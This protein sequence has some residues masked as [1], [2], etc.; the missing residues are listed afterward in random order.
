M[1]KKQAYTEMGDAASA[2]EVEKEIQTEQE[3]KSYD[4]KLHNYQI[5][6]LQAQMDEQRALIQ[7]GTLTARHSGYVTYVMDISK[8]RTAASNQNVVVVSDEDDVYIE[9]TGITLKTYAYSDYPVKYAKIN[10]KDYDV[11]EYGYAT[12]EL[13]FAQTTGNFPYVRLKTKDTV[14][15]S[16]GDVVPVYYCKEDRRN[17]LV[18]GNDSLYNEGDESFVYVQ[19]EDEE[20]KRRDVELGA[21]DDNYTEVLGGV[22]E[23]EM[24]YYSSDSTVPAD[25]DEY[26]VT[27]AD[28]TTTQTTTSYQNADS[29]YIITFADCDAK[30]A[31][32]AVKEGESVK[33]GDLLCTLDTGGSVAALT[34]AGYAVKNEEESYQQSVKNYDASITDLNNQI[35]E[36]RNT[37]E[38][39]AT[40]TDAVQEYQ[41]NHLYKEEQLSLEIDIIAHQKEIARLQHE[42]DA[43]SLNATYASLSDGSNGVNIYAEADG[44]IADIKKNAGDAVS[45][46]DEILSTGYK[47]ND[48]LLVKM[49]RYRD[50]SNTELKSAKLGQTITFTGSDN[51][52]YTGSCTGTC[53]DDEKYYLSTIDGV[54]YETVSKAVSDSVVQFYADVDDESFY[55]DMPETT[56]SFSDISLSSVT[57][58]PKSMVYTEHDKAKNIDFNYVWKLENGQFIKQYVLNDSRFSSDE[59]VVILS[60]VKEGDVL[61]NEVSE[62]TGEEDR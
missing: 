35:L 50:K 7:N 49:V 44:V 8:D 39:V 14:Q 11:E 61:A 25:Y 15:L 32:I 18:V 47:K 48:K 31:S 53:G 17:V 41:Q 55:T 29:S 43:K 57:A 54:V 12:N 33:K 6:K 20:L 22:D 26:E 59:N 21:S 30:V 1:I 38:P 34:E 42:Y 51:K 24:V 19:G 36:V 16:L 58:L 9:L 27:V 60:G 62:S 56:V 2:S 46:G 5:E 52:T 45:E 23:G 3:N 13:I 40:D 10:G 4:E 28:F 37:P